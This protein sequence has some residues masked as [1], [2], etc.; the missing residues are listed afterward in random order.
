MMSAPGTIAI[1]LMAACAEIGGCFAVWSWLRLGRSAWWLVP[2]VLALAG[3]A[4]LLTLV[5]SAAAGRAYAAYGGVY[6]ACS[7]GWL[8]GIEGVRPDRWDVM[9]ALVCLV[10]AGLIL[11]GPRGG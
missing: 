5:D 4:W 9:G 11:F 6:I 2:G 8:W 10:G 3:F 1:Y 7:L